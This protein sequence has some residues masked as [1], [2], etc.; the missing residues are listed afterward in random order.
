MIGSR[1]ARF[2]TTRRQTGA[3][4]VSLCL[5][6]V[7]ASSLHLAYADAPITLAEY[8]RV[9]ADTL[10]LVEQGNDA[11]RFQQAATM[12]DAVRAVRLDTGETMTVTNDPLLAEMRRANPD[13]GKVRARLRALRDALAVP[14]GPLNPND[15][16]KLHDLL[17]K[18]PFKQ[19]AS[20]NWFIRL[21]DELLSRLFGGTV[22]GIFDMRYVIVALG[23]VLIVAVLV[24]FAINLRGNTASEAVLPA[25]SV[26][27][28]ANLTAS[29]ALHNAQRLAS[30]GDYR[31]AVRQLY[32]ST[33][34]RLDERG[35]LRYDR[36]LTN[37]EYLR[38]V[39]SAPAIRD[40]LQPIVE[41]F[42]HI[43][44]G[45][46]PI[47]ATEFAE[48]QRNVDAIRQL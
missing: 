42:D 17:N 25:E 8:R 27:D 44:Y 15:Q 1:V 23:F 41:T 30:A 21:L 11:A 31:A 34:L 20:D 33:L 37:R 7:L 10:A 4:V 32:L 40:A 45:F 47:S 38:A 24:Y 9:V 35:R 14:T 22:Q 28:E 19:E 13:V 3:V 6:Y 29:A 46:A 18:P 43:W 36:S 12:L 2:A 5:A 48:Y 39:S 26:T 16:E